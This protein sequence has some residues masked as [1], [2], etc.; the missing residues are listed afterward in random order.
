MPEL[1]E[2]FKVEIINLYKTPTF[3][4]LFEKLYTD[5]TEIENK[6]KRMYEIYSPEKEKKYG[7]L[8]IEIKLL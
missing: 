8:G 3:K 2:T 7:V 6:V 4:E 1:T 5:E